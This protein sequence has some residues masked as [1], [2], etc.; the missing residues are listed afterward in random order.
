MYAFMYV[1]MYVCMYCIARFGCGTQPAL[2]GYMFLV[3]GLDT[4]LDAASSLSTKY[5]FGF[6]ML[7]PVESVFIRL[8]RIRLRSPELPAAQAAIWDYFMDKV[9][10]WLWDLYTETFG[11]KN[12]NAIIVKN[13]IGLRFLCMEIALFH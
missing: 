8:S 7:S 10:Y 6:G 2:Y 1:C 5:V 11:G 12:K 4:G 3:L 13:T 9:P